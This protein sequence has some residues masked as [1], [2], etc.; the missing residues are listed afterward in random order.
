M[1]KSSTWGQARLPGVPEHRH[2]SDRWLV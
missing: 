1:Q 2:G